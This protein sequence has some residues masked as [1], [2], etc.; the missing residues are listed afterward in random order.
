MQGRVVYSSFENN[1]QAGF[2][3]QLSPEAMASGIYMLKLT[4]NGQQR[5]DKISIQK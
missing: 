4:G 2:V 3:K 1:V 5:M